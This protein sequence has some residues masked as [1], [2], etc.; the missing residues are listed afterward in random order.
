[1]LTYEIAAIP[2]NQGSMQGIS[3][4]LARN[5]GPGFRQ[6]EATD[7]PDAVLLVVDGP[8][9]N[10]APGGDGLADRAVGLIETR[11]GAS[12]VPWRPGS[13]HGFC[14]PHVLV[15]RDNGETPDDDAAL[16]S[17]LTG[18]V[19]F[20]AAIKM[21]RSLQDSSPSPDDLRRVPGL[22]VNHLNVLATDLERS[23]DFYRR[24]LGAR[25]CYNLGP[26]KAV[27]EIN[28]FDLFIELTDSVSYPPGFHFGVRTDPAGV[29]ALAERALADGNAKVVQGNGPAPGF[30]PG[31]D[32]VRTAVYFEDP[33]GLLIEVYSPEVE[34]VETNPQL[35][36]Q[37]LAQNV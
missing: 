24:M 8:V 10:G 25:Y 22:L 7:H 6:A 9:S 4:S 18:F 3:Q 13:E 37:H 27:L 31:P 1:M 35:I 17:W 28:G 5:A 15:L 11:R 14:Y 26:K 12:S 36:E 23:K 21:W 19:T 34:M 2:A 32:G 29:R 16:K 33:D 20:A 30:H